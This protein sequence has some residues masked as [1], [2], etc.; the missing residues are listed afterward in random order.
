MGISPLTKL[1]LR[2]PLVFSEIPL[3]DGETPPVS[4]EY[5]FLFC[6]K[7]NPQQTKSIEPEKE[8]FL[9]SFEFAGHT[10]IQA[11]HLSQSGKIDV[12]SDI[13]PEKT[14]SLPQ[15]VYLF[16]QQRSDKPL[17][18]PEWLDLA[19]EQQKDGLWEREK[20]EA[21]LYV[22]FL[23]EDEAFVTQVFRKVQYAD[24]E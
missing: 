22:R 19:I 21:V 23:Y 20:P 5:E 15:G 6:Y 17:T 7:L 2:A 10:F 4:S 14:V 13:T 16:M 3:K 1:H 18:Q 8:R 12:E 11:N 24:K 9:D